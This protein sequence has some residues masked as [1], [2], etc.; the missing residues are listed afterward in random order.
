MTINNVDQITAFGKDNVEALVKSGTLAVK[1]LEELAKAY[2]AIANQSIEQ[3]TAA[4]KA[5]TAV[6][7]PGDLQ[8]IYSDIAKQNIE[9]FLAESRKLQELT[10]SIMT[11]SLAPL[12]ARIEALSGLF[13]VA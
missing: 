13:K 9:T 12:S 11:S 7:H 1:G 4:V 10:S 3:T 6:R 2:T 8:T 5:L